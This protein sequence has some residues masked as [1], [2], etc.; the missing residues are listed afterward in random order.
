MAREPKYRIVGFDGYWK[1][2]DILPQY[3]SH[4]ISTRARTKSE[5]LKIARNW[6]R[7]NPPVSSTMRKWKHDPYLFIEE[8]SR[9]Y[10]Y[11]KARWSAEGSS[12]EEE[13]NRMKTQ[14][15]KKNPSYAAAIT[16]VGRKKN[17]CTCYLNKNG[18][19]KKV[20][21][22]RASGKDVV[23][24]EVSDSQIAK[25]RSWGESGA[26][27]KNPGRQKNPLKPETTAAIG[28]AIG[29]G[30]GGIAGPLSSA[31]LAAIGSFIGSNYG[32]G[33][34]SNPAPETELVKRLKF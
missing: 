21:D 29:G 8:T 31:A 5:A 28:A 11:T 6:M 27:T 2:I 1:D 17:P 25:I 9:G 12:W 32:E 24:V 10:T 18:I 14:K 4:K 23:A 26:R 19:V 34:R 7:N 16:F 15:R 22:G 13:F 20:A 30:L 33:R 3:S